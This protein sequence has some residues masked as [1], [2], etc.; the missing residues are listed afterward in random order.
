MSGKHTDGRRTPA[1][2]RGNL[3]IL[4]YKTGRRIPQSGIYRVLHSEHRLPHD[5]TLLGGQ[6]FPRC[7]QC[8]NDVQFELLR[9][10]P[11]INDSDFHVVVYELPEKI[12]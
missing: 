3:E 4:R 2:E 11:E 5:V 7:A 6:Y 9:A 1:R 12:A 10:A 8:G